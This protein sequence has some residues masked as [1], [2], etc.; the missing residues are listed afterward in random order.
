MDLEAEAEQ[1]GFG[2]EIFPEDGNESSDADDIIDDSQD[3]TTN[4]RPVCIFLIFLFK[5]IN[6]YSIAIRRFCSCS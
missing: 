5:S 6:K 4:Q 1:K 3:S 2:E